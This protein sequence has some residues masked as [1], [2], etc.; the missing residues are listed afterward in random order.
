[1]SDPY[2]SNVA[3]AMHMDESPLVDLKEHALTITNVAR[4]SSQAAP[5]TGNSYSAFFDYTT[6]YFTTPNSSD[7]F[8]GN[9]P[10]TISFWCYKIYSGDAIPIAFW[11][12]APSAGYYIWILDSG[13][14]KIQAFDNSSVAQS[15]TSASS[16]VPL[17]T[18][19][20]VEISTDGT[21]LRIRVDG[22]TEGSRAHFAI[23]NP[24][25]VFRVGAYDTSNYQY[26]GYLDDLLITVGVQRNSSD[27]TP[28]TAPFEEGPSAGSVGEVTGTS[29]A[30]GIAAQNFGAGSA[31][32][33]S[34]AI[35]DTAQGKGEGSVTG[36]SSA[37]GVNAQNFSS[38][39]VTGTSSA[40]A[41]FTQSF[42]AGD[43]TGTSTADG[44]AGAIGVPA[45]GAGTSAGTSTS[46]AQGV[47]GYPS[48]SGIISGWS[49]AEAY[50][51]RDKGAGEADGESLAIAYNPVHTSRGISNGGASV[52]GYNATTASRGS[53]IGTSG[54][55]GV[56]PY[57]SGRGLATGSATISG[58]GLPN[59]V[60]TFVGKGCARGTSCAT[61]RVPCT[62]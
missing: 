9:A 23:K 50:T 43:V 39:E 32:G 51:Y 41:A 42:G 54:A 22:V 5:L 21:T 34:S 29:E 61:S 4:S 37:D 7:L 49:V 10:W 17:N 11:S 36:T 2:W 62:C 31:V 33:D 59:A 13:A 28:P 47:R 12:T 24:T 60:K 53:C 26:E 48:S 19:T 30:S 40:D 44:T 55:F 18:W 46:S 27:F 6:H 3:L 25:G 15:L 56:N 45:P 8:L 35:G 52:F 38:G 16:V 14:V 57:R 58:K 20:H 1:M